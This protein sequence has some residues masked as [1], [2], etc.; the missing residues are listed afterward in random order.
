[1]GMGLTGMALLRQDK[2][3]GIRRLARAL[4]ITSG[5]VAKW[6]EIPLDRVP[7]VERVTGYSRKLL[8]PDF[9]WDETVVPAGVLP[10]AE[11]RNR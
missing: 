2:K 11:C 4:G 6:R 7:D 3:V 10:P 1:M 8:R 9:Q 5:A